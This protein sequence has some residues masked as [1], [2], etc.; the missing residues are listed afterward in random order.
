[1]ES[2]SGQPQ[3]LKSPRRWEASEAGG[4]E[5]RAVLG[6]AKRGFIGRGGGFRSRR[7]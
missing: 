4:A 5:E 6:E 7:R 2:L 1:M 3:E